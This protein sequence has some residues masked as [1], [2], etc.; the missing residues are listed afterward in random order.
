MC[1]YSRLYD[2]VFLWSSLEMIYF[3]AV[4]LVVNAR[5]SLTAVRCKTRSLETCDSTDEFFAFHG[6]NRTS[7][8]PVHPVT[9][10]NSKFPLVTVNSGYFWNLGRYRGRLTIEVINGWAAN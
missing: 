7:V 8:S 4:V 3:C 9:P 6:S 2:S 1:L 10:G 5:R